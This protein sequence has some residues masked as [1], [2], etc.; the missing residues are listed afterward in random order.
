[1]KARSWIMAW[2]AW[3]VTVLVWSVILGY[4]IQPVPSPLP[5]Q[6]CACAK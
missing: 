2:L 3:G 4:I 6:E 1:M 5:P